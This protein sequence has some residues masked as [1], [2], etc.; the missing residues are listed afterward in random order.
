MKQ[1]LRRLAGFAELRRLAGFAEVIRFA[2]AVAAALA[3]PA[4]LAQAQS[5]PSQPIRLVVPYPAGGN[6]DA[7]ARALALQLERQMGQS[8]VIDNRAGASGVI[9][10]DI[11]ARAAPNGYTMLFATSSLVLNQA[12]RE[13]PPYDIERDFAAVTSICEGQGHLLVVHPSVRAQN[14][15]EFIALARNPKERIHYG[16]SGT[17]NLSRVMGDLFNVRAGTHMV[18]VPYKGSSPA[19]NA[20]LGGEIEAMFLTAI[21]GL[22]PVKA[23]KLRAIGFT[24]ASR[25]KSLPDVPSI[26][27]VLPTYRIDGGWMGWLAPAKTPPQIVARM[28]AEIAKAVKGPKLRELMVTGGYEPVA[29]PPE[30][31]S[32]FMREELVRFREIAKVANIK[33]E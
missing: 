22:G 29:T 13:K 1:I 33:V 19:M 2:L 6:P 5:Y 3:A 21:I 31:F 18:N 25:L 15:A 11:A 30:A 28:H 23:G 10:M 32:K 24:G 8:I 7:V 26:A 4:A 9:G 16:S 14:L 27:E 20:L 17:A 12:L